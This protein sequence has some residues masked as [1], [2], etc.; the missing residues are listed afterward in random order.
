MNK[1]SNLLDIFI[2]LLLG[3]CALGMPVFTALWIKRNFPAYINPDM[4]DSYTLLALYILALMLVLVVTMMIGV[5]LGVLLIRPFFKRE[6]VEW[7]YTVP[8]IAYV[9]PVIHGI[10]KLVYGDSPKE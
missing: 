3:S 8:K 9:T 1:K 2:L 6:D 7:F 5:F 10:F 4:G